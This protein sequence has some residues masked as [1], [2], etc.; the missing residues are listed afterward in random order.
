MIAIL[1]LCLDLPW[2]GPCYYSTEMTAGPRLQPSTAV[3]ASYW[4]AGCRLVAG[5]DEVGRGPLA[6]PVYTAAVILG[7]ACRAGWLSELRD[8]KVLPASDR[9]RLSQVIRAEAL[10]FALGWA[11]VAEIGA[12]GIG[13]ANKMAMMR[14]INGLRLRPGQVLIDGPLGIDIATPQKT[15]VDGDATCCTIAAASIVAK[16]ARDALMRRL[17]GVYPGYRFASNKG[18]ATRDHLDAIGRLGT[19]GQHRNSWLAVQR[20]AAQGALDLVEVLEDADAAG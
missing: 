1:R 10:D 4:D 11:S 16:V 7:P 5:V 6:G 12:W 8:S 13:P 15:I 20:R 9:E 3:E 2:R 14:A 19:C 18:Y 17:D